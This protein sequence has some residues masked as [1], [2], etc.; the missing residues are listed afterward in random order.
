MKSTVIDDRVVRL[1]DTLISNK[2]AHAIGLPP[3]RCIKVLI[4]NR[5]S[6]RKIVIGLVDAKFNDGWHS[7]DGAIRSGS[8]YWLDG[9]DLFKYFK[10]HR[11]SESVI[12]KDDLLFRKINLKGKKGKLLAALPDCDE[13]MV[14][15]DEYV[16]GCSCDGLGRAGHCLV[17]S[18]DLLEFVDVEKADKGE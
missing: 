10:L 16:E 1:G 17:V 13:G 12:I 8:G 4:I 14:E 7:L 6:D 3:N 9:K 2:K 5:N 11:L 15:F 18:N